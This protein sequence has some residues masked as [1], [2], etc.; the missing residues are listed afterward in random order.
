[1]DPKPEPCKH[2]LAVGWPSVERRGHSLYCRDFVAAPDQKVG[3]R[4]CGCG[5]LGQDAKCPFDGYPTRPRDRLAAHMAL[6]GFDLPSLK[7]G[8]S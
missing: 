1:M 6:G 3:A 5:Y 7:G 2:C 8:A 4:Y